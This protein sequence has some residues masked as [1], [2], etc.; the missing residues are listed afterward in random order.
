GLL[1]GDLPA[2]Q[3]VTGPDRPTLPPAAVICSPQQAQ[4]MQMVQTAR[5]Y[6]EAGEIYQV[7]LSQQQEYSHTAPPLQVYDRLC[8]MNPSPYMYYLDLGDQIIVG[9]SPEMLVKVER[10][11]VT[12]CPIAGTRPRGGT[13]PEDERLA[14]E[15]LHDPKE[16]A[17]HLMLV[18]LGRN[19]LGR[20]ARPGSVQVEKF[21]ELERYSH[22]IHL[23]SRLRAQLL[24]QTSPLAV[25]KA[26]FP[27]GTVTGAPKVRAMQIIAELEPLPRGVYAG[28]IGYW[29]WAAPENLDTA[30]AIRTAVF[31]QGRVLIRAGA[32]IVYDSRP[33][34]EYREIQ[35]KLG[36]LLACLGEG[37][38]IGAGD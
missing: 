15:L 35:N 34:A 36:A 25:L 31:S 1:T 7:V 11:T 33:D 29:Q 9:S 18:D 28:A 14:Q 26:C 2:T 24:P 5:Q 16:R 22:V 17:E 8:R 4:F 27:A 21:M 23:V 30:I 6:I 12:T 10:D 37:K 3:M 19:D 20:V 13:E 38:A 32:G